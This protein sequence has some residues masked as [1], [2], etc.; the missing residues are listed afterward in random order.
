[1]QGRSGG[2][3]DTESIYFNWKTVFIIFGLCLRRFGQSDLNRTLS[4]ILA[5]YSCKEG[6]KRLLEL[7]LKKVRI[8]TIF[9][10]SDFQSN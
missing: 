9:K 6:Q 5:A 10:R 4:V 3:I 1:M 7:A 8:L 2:R